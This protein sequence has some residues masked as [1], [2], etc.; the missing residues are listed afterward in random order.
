M[1]RPPYSA[2]FINHLFKYNKIQFKNFENQFS[3]VINRKIFWKYIIYKPWKITNK[4]TIINMESERS[5]FWLRLF[6]YQSG[7]SGFGSFTVMHYVPPFNARMMLFALWNYCNE[8]I[9]TRLNSCS[10]QNAIFELTEPHFL[11]RNQELYYFVLMMA[12][13]LK[14]TGL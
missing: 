3:S 7:I 2:Y 1:M 8:L 9:N 14:T 5:V 13:A 4:M 12:D 6:K 11:R 10:M